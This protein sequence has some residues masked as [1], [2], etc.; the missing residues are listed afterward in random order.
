M[1]YVAEQQQEQT[2]KLILSHLVPV[3]VAIKC[4]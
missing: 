3:G 2:Y 1:A 4:R